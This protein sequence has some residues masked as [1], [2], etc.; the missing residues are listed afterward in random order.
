MR[1][2]KSAITRWPACA[3][4]LS[5][6]TAL[7]LLASP[8]A[9]ARSLP[10]EQ[11]IFDEQGLPR[12]IV[13]SV[14]PDQSL[15]LFWNERTY[16]RRD[17]FAA[18]LHELGYLQLPFEYFS[19]N[20]S[21]WSAYRDALL[22]GHFWENRVGTR[23]TPGARTLIRYG[24]TFMWNEK[25]EANLDE[26]RT[27]S[28][29]MQRPSAE[30]F[31][32]QH[33]IGLFTRDV[34]RK[35][36]STYG[37][38]FAAEV[39][40][41]WLERQ[42]GNAALKL[43]IRTAIAEVKQ[44]YALNL[45]NKIK[46]YS[47]LIEQGFMQTFGQNRLQPLIDELHRLGVEVGQFRNDPVG[48]IT[49]NA[50]RVHDQLFSWMTFHSQQRSNLGNSVIL[51]CASK[52]VPEVL[53]ALAQL[54]QENRLEV[55]IRS[56]A[57]TQIPAKHMSQPQKLVKVAAVITLAGM[58]EGSFLSDW[59]GSGPQRLFIRKAL[60]RDAV[61]PAAIVTS[62]TGFFDMSTLALKRFSD[63]Y[64]RFLPS[65]RYFS[66]VGIIPGN[67]IGRDPDIMN[68]QNQLSI[69]YAAFHGA[70]DGYIE[71]PG[72][73]IPRAWGLP[74]NEIVFDSSHVILD[75]F[76]DGSDLQDHKVRQEII[77]GIFKAILDDI[78]G[79]KL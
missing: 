60:N 37:V 40:K 51:I 48:S 57:S 13:N 49:E 66:F 30:N 64:H 79:A 9:H 1:F 31:L 58:M 62:L 47:V 2:I 35:L 23:L 6:L 43:R 12:C 5:A 15:L 8:L 73:V 78:E 74:S 38:G 39:F 28:S 56:A 36:T 42:P 63:S 46:N 53:T 59:A 19:R 18:T 45:K 14:A 75:G 68:L 29:V 4:G 20:C 27:G 41:R 67:G 3:F 52:G 55:S 61:D 69:P 50:R 77:D 32:S 44:D 65:I 33:T 7:S 25:V 70:N 10:N 22:Q 21:H 34:N 54:N 72:T 76:Y 17:V 26:V 11:V 24:H 71:Y 16:Y